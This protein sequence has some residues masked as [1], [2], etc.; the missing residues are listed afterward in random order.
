MPSFYLVVDH[1]HYITIY[2]LTFLY[3]Q[4]HSVDISVVVLSSWDLG[5]I[6][7][8]LFLCMSSTHHAK[9]LSRS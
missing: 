6:R 4:Y 9:W 1:A 2:G 5:Q 7:F 8:E 3:H